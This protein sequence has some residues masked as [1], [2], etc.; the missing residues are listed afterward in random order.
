M[1]GDK[2]L[3]KCVLSHYRLPNPNAPMIN[4]PNLAGFDPKQY[5]RFLLFF[6]HRPPGL[7]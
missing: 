3:K 5:T 7:C 4:G 6:R 1:K 2:E